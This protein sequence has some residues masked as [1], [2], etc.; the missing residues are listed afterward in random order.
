MADSLKD[1]VRAAAF[2]KLEI[3]DELAD[4]FAT[5]ERKCQRSNSSRSDDGA[6]HVL[7][8]QE[9]DSQER[10]SAERSQAAAPERKEDPPSQAAPERKE[11]P[12]SQAAPERK[13]DPPGPGRAA[14]ERKEDP[15]GQAPDP[16]GGTELNRQLSNEFDVSEEENTKPPEPAVLA[17]FKRPATRVPKA[18]AKGSM[19]MKRPAACM[20][21]SPDEAESNKSE[22]VLKKPAAGP[23]VPEV[24]VDS[25]AAAATTSPID[26]WDW[27]DDR[28]KWIRCRLPGDPEP[29]AGPF[30]PD[31]PTIQALAEKMVCPDS[32]H[33]ATDASEDRRFEES[34]AVTGGLQGKKAS[35]LRVW[36]EAVSSWWRRADTDMSMWAAHLRGAEDRCGA[37]HTRG[38]CLRGLQSEGCELSGGPLDTWLLSLGHGVRCYHAALKSFFEDPEQVFL[39][40]TTF[41]T[42][43]PQFDRSFFAEIGITNEVHQNIFER[44]FENRIQ[45]VSSYPT[46]PTSTLAAAVGS[47]SCG[48]LQEGS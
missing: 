47:G 10:D 37:S 3:Q 9:R 22:A 17:T 6:V 11:D 28:I 4:P 40:Y 45:E 7:D 13:E 26:A 23:H 21:T 42:D 36:R 8:S 24:A 5:P 39:A 29:E 33:G 16:S 31:R 48:G 41:A 30:T 32:P 14:A 12:P 25:A 43:A 35:R 38:R 15:P 44:W 1:A 27:V 2:R 34:A 20:S 18:K 19:P 46:G